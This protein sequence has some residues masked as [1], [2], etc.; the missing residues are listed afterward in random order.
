MFAAVVFEQENRSHVSVVLR[1]GHLSDEDA[2]GGHKLITQSIMKSNRSTTRPSKIHVHMTTGKWVHPLHARRGEGGE[3]ASS[4]PV[5]AD[6]SKS[7]VHEYHLI[8]SQGVRIG[9]HW[10]TGN[11]RRISRSKDSC[12]NTRESGNQHHCHHFGVIPQDAAGIRFP[13]V[14][15]TC[16]V[17]E[18]CMVSSSDEDDGHVVWG[19]NFPQQEQQ[20]RGLVCTPT[21][22]KCKADSRV[23]EQRREQ[24]GK[25]HQ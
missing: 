1:M 10:P 15:V 4:T 23:H 13:T 21:G 22:E 2:F 18:L 11:W 14:V 19:D 16:L 5:T 7:S 25:R 20:G 24:T 8:K 9:P 3:F 12:Y 6:L 17:D